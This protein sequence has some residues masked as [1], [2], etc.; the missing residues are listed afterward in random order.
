MKNF[1][2]SI[3]S[4]IDKSFYNML[5]TE[6]IDKLIELENNTTFR[7]EN[8]PSIIIFLCTYSKYFKSLNN[9]D[10]SKYI[11]YYFNKILSDINTQGTINTSLTEGITGVAFC[12]AHMK[13]FNPDNYEMIDNKI[14]KLFY[15]LTTLQIDI[16]RK[17]YLLHGLKEK[18]YDLISGISG[19]LMYLLTYD[20]DNIFLIKKLSSFLITLFNVDNFSKYLITNKNIDSNY[21]KSIHKDGYYNLSVSHGIVTPLYLLTI[22]KRKKIYVQGLDETIEKLTLFF[23]SNVSNINNLYSWNGIIEKNK[24]YSYDYN[25]RNSWCYGSLSIAYILLKTSKLTGNKKLYNMAYSS[26]L[27]FMKKNDILNFTSPTFCHGLSGLLLILKNLYILTDDLIFHNVM[28]KVVQKIIDSS[29]KSYEFG[30]KDIDYSYTNNTLSR[31]EEINNNIGIMKG[32]ISVLLSLLEII[33][34]EINILSNIFLL[35]IN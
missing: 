4:I 13:A 17:D 30:F 14:K 33:N 15:K 7:L 16:L 26:T 6:K 8:Y 29:D 27:D 11:N 28:L 25:D 31:Y 3:I 9:I 20:K 19:N 10:T 21:M 12:T 22:I 2:K 24:S 18:H 35:N 23:E 32:S 1:N 5:S 34:N